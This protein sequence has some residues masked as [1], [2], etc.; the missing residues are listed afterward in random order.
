VTNST[1]HRHTPMPRATHPMRRSQLRPISPKA[2]RRAAAWKPV[3]AAAFEAS[4]GMCVF[5]TS[6]R[7][8]TAPAVAGHHGKFRSQ[9]GTDVCFPMCQKHH[10]WIHQHPRVAHALG[11]VV[12]SWEEA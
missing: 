2:R 5:K 9:G 12:L 8:C 11:Y 4:G 7:S 3:R 6:R 1:L 10:D